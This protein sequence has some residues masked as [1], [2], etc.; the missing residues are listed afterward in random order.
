MRRFGSR[1]SLSSAGLVLP[2]TPTNLVVVTASDTQL[3]L[4]WNDNSTNETGFQIERSPDGSSWS[5]IHTTAANVTTYSDTGRTQN[6]GYFYRVRAIKGALNSA[7]SNVAQGVTWY[8][9]TQTYLTGVGLTGDNTEGQAMNAFFVQIFGSSVAMN[10]IDVLCMVSPAGFPYSLYDVKRNVFM[11]DTGIDAS[12][13]EGWSF[14]ESGEINTGFNLL[15]EAVASSGTS[16][17]QMVGWVPLETNA[18]PEYVF[19]AADVI[20]DPDFGFG[21]ANADTS[22][23]QAVAVIG[24]ASNPT[25]NFDSQKETQ[26]FYAIGAGGDDAQF[27]SNGFA[28]SQ[29]TFYPSSVPGTA[30]PDLDLYIGSINVNG[31]GTSNLKGF[32]SFFC[33][34]GM[35][36]SLA[37][38]EAIKAGWENYR[39]TYGV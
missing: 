14:Q 18:S 6:T 35:L 20:T 2:V 13:L 21:L 25:P 5:L 31:T 16:F 29:G 33:Q 23:N 12:L 7:Y 36:S 24:D 30:F 38:M 28:Y 11:T 3:N 9:E 19:G 15:T 1:R 26:G 39:G 32:V 4:S 17:L 34:S 10:E 27:P 22:G 8:T 37:K